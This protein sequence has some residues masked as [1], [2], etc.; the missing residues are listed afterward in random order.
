MGVPLLFGGY[1]SELAKDYNAGVL[2]GADGRV[3]DRY[4]KQ[5]LLIFGGVGTLYGAV[6]GAAASRSTA[7]TRS[8]RCSRGTSPSRRSATRSRRG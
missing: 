1:V 4:L 6:V 7:P 5:V 8:S 2:L 3:A